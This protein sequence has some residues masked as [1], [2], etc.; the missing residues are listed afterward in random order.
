MRVV[1]TKIF[2]SQDIA[3]LKNQLPDVDFQFFRNLEELK[4]LRRFIADVDVFLGPP[5][6][7]DVI[8]AAAETLKLIQIPWSGVDGMDFAACA[9]HSISVANSHTNA[10]SVAELAVTI[11]LDALKSTAFHDRGFREGRWYRPESSEGFFPPRLLTGL[12]V[13]Y[14][15]YGSI[16]RK[17][18]KMLSGF[19]V[20]GS[21]LTFTG[22]PQDNVLVYDRETQ[23]NEFLESSDIIFIAA[24]LTRETKKIINSTAF[25]HMKDSCILVN[26][27]RSDLIDLQALHQALSQ[28]SIAGAALDVHWNGLSDKEQRLANDIYAMPNVVLSPHRGGFCLGDLPHLRGAVENLQK[29][30]SGRIDE[31]DGIINVERGY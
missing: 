24:P 9:D 4:E 14:L 2:K 22:C 3:Y 23:F 20:H 31:V 13:G 10:D 29:V 11:C 17:I 8:A 21:A 18:H 27:S 7:A 26:V 19:E 1:A 16:G 6:D 25:S 5:P 28:K 12:S 30:A 15:G